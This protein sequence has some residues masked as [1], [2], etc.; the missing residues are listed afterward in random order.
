MAKIYKQMAYLLPYGTAS[1]TDFARKLGAIVENNVIKVNEEMATN[2]E[3]LYA[4]AANADLSLFNTLQPLPLPSHTSLLVY[5]GV[6]LEI[7]S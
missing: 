4:P 1:S 6:A 5:T 3:G 7:T 2:V